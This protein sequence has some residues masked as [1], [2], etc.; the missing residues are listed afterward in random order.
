MCAHEHVCDDEHT[1]DRICT[2]CGTVVGAV[3]SGTPPDSGMVTSSSTMLGGGSPK[4]V[5]DSWLASSS[6]SSSVPTAQMLKARETVANVCAGLYLDSA[7]LVDTVLHIFLQTNCLKLDYENRPEPEEEERIAISLELPDYQARHWPHTQRLQAPSWRVPVLE[8]RPENEIINM[9]SVAHRAKLAFAILEALAREGSPRSPA[10]IATHL[11]VLPRHILAVENHCCTPTTYSAPSQYVERAVAFLDLPFYVGMLA[12]NLCKRVEEDFYGYRPEG[13]VAASI[14]F[15]VEKVREKEH[16]PY[17]FGA[18]MNLKMICNTLG[19]SESTAGNCFSKLPKLI[20]LRRR[21]WPDEMTR[22][23][24]RE[25][26][27]ADDLVAK[28]CPYTLWDR[29]P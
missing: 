29:Y 7:V 1:G 14:W 4:V 17:M 20:Q 8:Q 16:S 3:F 13:L 5:A 27:Y 22:E 2:E 12:Q 19:I 24:A 18:D 21:F 15:I 9:S 23:Q 25:I 6:S 28:R 26:G 11:D 10:E